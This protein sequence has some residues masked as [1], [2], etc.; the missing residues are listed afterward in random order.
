MRRHQTDHAVLRAL[1]CPM[2]SGYRK[3]AL[4]NF[5]RKSV[6]SRVTMRHISC[7]RER[8]RSPMRSPKRFA[9][10]RGPRGR[11]RTGQRQ[12]RADRQSSW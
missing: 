4:R 10:A 11:D 12:L 1:V 9:T 8:M 6:P 5:W 2:A 7:R 3:L